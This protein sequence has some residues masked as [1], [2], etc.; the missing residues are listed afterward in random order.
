M[1][2]QEYKAYGI[3]CKNLEINLIGSRRPEEIILVGAHYDS[4]SGA[5]GANDNGSGI[6]AMLE[7]SRLSKTANPARTVRFLAFV[8]EEPPFFFTEL[9][10][11]RVYARV[12]R[13][14]DD[15]IRLMIALETIG[16]YRSEP[17]TQRYPPWL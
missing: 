5:P 10:G 4:V 3:H 9:Q 12:A 11:S 13:Q 16:Y 17:N 6:A 14:R 7:L 2:E 15:D 1:T 8:N